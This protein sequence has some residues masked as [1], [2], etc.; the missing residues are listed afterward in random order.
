MNRAERRRGS[1][2]WQHVVTRAEMAGV[3]DRYDNTAVMP[4]RA[5]VDVLMQWHALPAWKRAW[6]RLRGRH[7]FAGIGSLVY[8]AGS[9]GQ[10]EEQEE[11]ED[12]GS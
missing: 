1:N 7:P 6:L 4:I 12:A 8:D 11:P 5:L 9:V 2:Y 10:H 3:L